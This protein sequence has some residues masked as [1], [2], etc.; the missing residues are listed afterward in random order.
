MWPKWLSGNSLVGA[1][2]FADRINIF[3]NP[4]VLRHLQFDDKKQGKRQSVAIV[5]R[6][7]LKI[8]RYMPQWR[9][10]EV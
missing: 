6:Y 4:I 3:R 8:I 10:S 1:C 5:S 9:F 7:H 2:I